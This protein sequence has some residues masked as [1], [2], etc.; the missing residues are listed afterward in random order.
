MGGRGASSSTAANRTT[1]DTL[2][3]RWAAAKSALESAPA[4]FTSRVTYEDTAGSKLEFMGQVHTADGKFAGEFGATFTRGPGGMTAK[5]DNLLME[6][7]FQ[8]KGVGAAVANNMDTA[9]RRMGVTEVTLHAAQVGRYVWAKAGYNYDA[10]TGRQMASAF[11]AWLAKNGHDASE[12]SV[13]L[14]GAGALASS[15]HGKAFLLSD[16]P[17]WHGSKRLS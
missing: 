12:A 9:F 5:L 4:G 2:P 16:A 15:P 13:A 1:K 17:N 8:G 6:S 11:G 10:A 14:K 7:A 3:K